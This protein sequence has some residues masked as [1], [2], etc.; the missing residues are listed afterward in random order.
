[1]TAVFP[2][3]LAVVTREGCGLCEQ[4][5][6]D[7]HELGS[8]AALPPISAIDLQSDPGLEQRF[9]LEVPVLLLDGRVVCHGRLDAALLQRTLLERAS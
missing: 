4:T 6:E 1:M 7:L 5:V 3:G 2:A 9:I 8:R